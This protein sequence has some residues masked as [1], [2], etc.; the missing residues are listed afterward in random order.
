MVDDVANDEQGR[1]RKRCYVGRAGPDFSA[2][3]KALL[4]LKAAL[5]DDGDGGGGL[6]EGDQMGRDVLQPAP[7]HEHHEGGG[8]AKGGQQI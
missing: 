7:A 6:V 5:C 2:P 1:V 3:N 4:L 8:G